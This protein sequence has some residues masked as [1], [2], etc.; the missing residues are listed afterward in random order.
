MAASVPPT[1]CCG[2][3]SAAPG[4]PP[5]AAMWDA[6]KG[7]YTEKMSPAT[8]SLAHELYNQLG[9]FDGEKKVRVLETHCG[10]TVAAGRLL[11]LEA[12]ESYTACDFSPAMVEAAG[13]RLG[14]RAQT[15]LAQSVELPFGD[16]AFDC[17][18]SNLG[19]CCV[20][21]LGTKLKEARRVLAPGGRAA[22]S[23]RIADLEGDT[24]FRLVAETLKPFG[25]PPGP[26]REGLRLG[27]DLPAL[28][29]KVLEAGFSQVRAWRT[30]I[31]VP[32]RAGDPGSAGGGS[33]FVEWATSQ[34]QVAK[35]L[36]SLDEGAR[37]QALEALKAAG[38]A[39]S[40]QGALYVAVAVAVASV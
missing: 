25:L 17:Y 9:L 30:W 3:P 21:D 18:M 16:A 5:G 24:A 20:S 37:Q 38:E 33:P 8:A 27:K 11:P 4:V 28:K 13:K 19:C 36:A 34:G 14:E 7:W 40:E 12:V 6:M 26:D 39:P 2:V 32:L 29:A 22:M 10:D 31:T 15:V 35:F 1:G 23:M